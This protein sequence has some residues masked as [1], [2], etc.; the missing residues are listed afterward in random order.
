MDKASAIQHF[1]GITKLAEQLGISRQAIH[2]WP[3]NVPDR[4]AYQLHYMS[5]GALPL[6]APKETRQ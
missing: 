5:A 4:W 3:E 1:G 6:D 2:A